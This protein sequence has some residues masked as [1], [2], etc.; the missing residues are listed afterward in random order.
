MDFR[1]PPDFNHVSLDR[2]AA[3]QIQHPA[4]RD[5]QWSTGTPIEKWHSSLA[6][7][8]GRDQSMETHKRNNANELTDI[9]QTFDHVTMPEAWNLKEDSSW[10]QGAGYRWVAT[11]PKTKDTEISVSCRPTPL[12]PADASAFNALLKEPPKLLFDAAWENKPEYVNDPAR[13]ESI[14]AQVN[15]LSGVLGRSQLGDNQFSNADPQSATFHI[16]HL[17]TKLV[18][19]KEV[20]ALTG[21]FPIEGK[22]ARYLSG[23]L[24]SHEANGLSDVHRIIFQGTEKVQ[25]AANTSHFNKVLR[26]IVWK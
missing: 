22:P 4:A 14:R 26:S 8:Q 7:A 21:Y 18:N 19:G 10:H 5:S 24:A 16:E 20:L 15:A 23:V 9:G 12:A 17:E 6:I 11:H 3:D 1:P 2:P 13:Q 25:F